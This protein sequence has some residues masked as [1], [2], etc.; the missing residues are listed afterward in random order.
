MGIFELFDNDSTGFELKGLEGALK[1]SMQGFYNGLGLWVK[2]S[3]FEAEA[4]ASGCR[5]GFL[6]V[7]EGCG[8]RVRRF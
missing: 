4:V 8:L 3:G 5:V 2:G 7:F 1:G 6:G